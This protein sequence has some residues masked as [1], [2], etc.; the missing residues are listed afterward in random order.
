MQGAGRTVDEHIAT[1][2]IYYFNVKQLLKIGISF[3]A[4]K[5]MEERDINYLLAIEAAIHEVQEENNA[6]ARLS[7]TSSNNRNQW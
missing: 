3:S 1:R 7:N 4:I 2:L 5:E 6:K